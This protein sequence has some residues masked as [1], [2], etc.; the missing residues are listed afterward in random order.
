MLL[1]IQ[2]ALLTSCGGNSSSLADDNKSLDTPN[3]GKVQTSDVSSTGG[4]SNELDAADTGILVEDK[5]EVIYQVIKETHYDS[6]GSVTS[7]R[8]HTYDDN[9]N[10]LSFCD[11]GAGG[12]ITFLVEIDYDANNNE[13][14]RSVYRDGTLDTVYEYTYDSN[15]NRASS[16]THDYIDDSLSWLEFTHDDEGNLIYSRSNN[17]DGSLKRWTEYTY[18]KHGSKLSETRYQSD[19]SVES[20]E[21]YTYKYDANGNVLRQETYSADGTPNYW[22]EYEYDA[23]GNQIY[24]RSGYG[25]F[26]YSENVL[27]QNGDLIRSVYYQYGSNSEKTIL[28]DYEYTLDSD[29]NRISSRSYDKDGKLESEDT[30]DEYGNLIVSKSYDSSKAL[31]S[32]TEYEYQAFPANG[33]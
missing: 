33:Q 20:K 31:T 12:T 6:D 16:K 8:E 13:I 21:E 25:D 1:L 23:D 29:G 2:L 28:Y 17:A 18:D 10:E 26:I 24:S 9:A 30:Y 11:Y 32:W 15:G 22:S 14:K 4:T 19:G 3:Q 27:E 5:P 7:W